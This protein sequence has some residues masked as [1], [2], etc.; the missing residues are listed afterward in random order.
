MIKDVASLSSPW[1][2]GSQGNKYPPPTLFL[3]SNF[4]P[5]LP[6]GQTQSEVGKQGS[7][8]T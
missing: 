3:S 5:V 2:G 4:L 7:L 8:L 1:Q 6:I